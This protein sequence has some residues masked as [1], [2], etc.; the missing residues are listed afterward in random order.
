MHTTRQQILDALAAAGSRVSNLTSRA[1]YVEP[2]DEFGNF[3]AA[4]D[5]DGTWAIAFKSPPAAGHVP[6]VRLATLR[7]DYGV[8]CQ[9]TISGVTSNVRV[10]VVRCETN[11][12]EVKN[13]FATFVAAL[14]SELPATPTEQMIADAVERWVSLFWRLQGSPRKDVVGLIGELVV[15]DSGGNTSAWA[16]AWHNSPM[17]AIDF[18]FTSPRIEIEVKATTGRERI[19]N[20]AIHQAITSNTER[21]FASLMVELRDSGETVGDLARDIAERLITEDERRRFWTIIADSCGLELGDYMRTRFIRDTSANTL[22]LYRADEVP[23]PTVG[24]PMPI[25]VSDLR[26]RSDFSAASPVDRVLIL[27]Q[28]S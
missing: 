18:G 5:T 27:G 28:K 26:F 22:A 21:Y 15:L 19:H 24:L 12:L 14:V 7:A 23:V 4:V 10:S 6:A 11:D 13:L 1:L 17:D 9:L 8:R 16:A 20:L 3:M 2:L 25:G